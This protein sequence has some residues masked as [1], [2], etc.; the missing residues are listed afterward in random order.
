[1]FQFHLIGT[2]FFIFIVI[3]HIAAASTPTNHEKQQY[4]DNL[5]QKLD[6]EAHANPARIGRLFRHIRIQ[7]DMNQTVERIATEKRNNDSK[8]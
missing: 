2:V 8:S 7:H 6:S 1:M 3:S 5:L 4:S